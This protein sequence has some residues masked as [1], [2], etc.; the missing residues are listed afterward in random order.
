MSFV[1]GVCRFVAREARGSAVCVRF[2]EEHHLKGE[3]TR[4]RRIC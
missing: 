2:F 4:Q 3:R 1:L